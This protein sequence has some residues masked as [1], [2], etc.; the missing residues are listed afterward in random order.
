[1]Q[2]LPTARVYEKE[3]EFMP[4]G[5]LIDQV[6]SYLVRNVPKNGR[7][8]DL[9]CG[10][11]YLLGKLKDRRPDLVCKGVDIDQGFIEHAQRL[12]PTVEFECADALR[13]ATDD[14]FETIVCTAGVHHLPDD[15]QDQ[16]I[17]AIGRLLVRRGFAV[18]AD[19]YIDDYDSPRERLIAGA[20]LGY[21]YLAATI[22]NGATP[23]VIDAAVQVLRNDVLLI[24]WKTS[25][26]RRLSTL[27]RHFSHVKQHKTWPLENTRYGDYYFI[28]RR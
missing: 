9:M 4:W 2:N 1:M 28:V 7:V 24:E 8:L 25:V 26:R 15:A 14:R 21:K 10:P 23:D 18:I 3:F 6:L 22:A 11:G 16:F 17:A 5:K 20:R 19:P 12:Y 27:K 13:W